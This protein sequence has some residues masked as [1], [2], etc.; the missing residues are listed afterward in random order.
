MKA[1]YP[2]TTDKIIHKGV[3]GNIYK[4]DGI[5]K[6]ES[7]HNTLKKFNKNMEELEVI[8]IKVTKE[9]ES[10]IENLINKT[11]N[12]N[13][14][15]A[16]KTG[17]PESL[18]NSSGI[19]WQ[20]AIYDFVMESAK[21]CK[22]SIDE[23]IRNNSSK[24]LNIL[25]GG[26]HAEIDKPLGFCTINTMA[27]SSKYANEQGYKTIILDLDTHYSNGCIDILQNKENVSVYSLWNQK[28]DKWK[29]ME[30]EN[31][32]WH[33]KTNTIE[34]YFLYLKEALN[35]IKIY[36]P[37]IFIYHLGLDVLETDRMGGVKGMTEDKLIERE[38]IVS[39]FLKENKIPHIIF[40]GGAYINWKLGN[41]YGNKQRKYLTNLQVKLL[42][43][44]YV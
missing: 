31:N 23:I 12:K 10:E 33:K 3:N 8:E 37:D 16:Y 11:H 27:I 22:L 6:L 24:V 17:I 9:E 43:D 18:A 30:P 38:K 25:G 26:H 5:Q 36:K 4:L 15:E 39:N 21:V 32:I 19:M 34:E 42:K 40:M 14:L 2:I 41:E 1:F 28:I 44:L 29:Y 7:L 13:I 35:N 20:P